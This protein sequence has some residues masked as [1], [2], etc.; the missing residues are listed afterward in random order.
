M[1]E[2]NW[3]FNYD[4]GSIILIYSLVNGDPTGSM[5]NYYSF[6]KYLYIASLVSYN[7]F[8]LKR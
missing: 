1:F 6:F 5:M 2:Q 7:L 4:I 8:E 3:I